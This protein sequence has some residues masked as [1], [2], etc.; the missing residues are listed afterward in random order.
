MFLFDLLQFCQN[1][2]ILDQHTYLSLQGRQV[3]ALCQ[4]AR[5][6]CIWSAAPVL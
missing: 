2:M 5:E 6:S 4:R 1:F 3:T